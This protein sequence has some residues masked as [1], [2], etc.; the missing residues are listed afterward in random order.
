[1]YSGRTS[2]PPWSC[3]TSASHESGL[4]KIVK[5]TPVRANGLHLHVEKVNE[6]TSTFTWKFPPKK[7]KMREKST[8][9]IKLW[10]D[11]VRNPKPDWS[12]IRQK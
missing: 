5:K 7:S 12:F 6:P 3:L 9:L 11:E 8:I 2:T 4:S 1:M 10:S